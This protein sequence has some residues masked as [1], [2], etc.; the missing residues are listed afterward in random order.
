MEA[1]QRPGAIRLEEELAAIDS[2]PLEEWAEQRPSGNSERWAIVT[3][4]FYR[5]ISDRL[6]AGARA[7][8]EERGVEP[9]Q[10]DLYEV[11]GAFELPLAARYCALAADRPGGSARYRAV[12][13]L[14]VVI[15]GETSHYDHI[16]AAAARGLQSVQLE[17]G[18][19][20]TFG[21][22]T[23]ENREQALAR[24]G[25]DK[26]DSGRAAADAAWRMADLRFRLLG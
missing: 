10:I 9:G 7:C 12:I 18:T 25:G 22:L 26:R 24:S 2:V 16:C 1:E 17:T 13:S 14:G 20:C 3:A 21:L 4:T 11:P 19:P 5:E 6:V 23:V 15:R 8:L